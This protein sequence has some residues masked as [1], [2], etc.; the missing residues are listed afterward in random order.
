MIHLPESH[1]ES[2][3]A[4]LEE[5]CRLAPWEAVYDNVAFRFSGA[6]LDGSVAV[7]VG[8][9]GASTGFLVWPSAEDF[10]DFRDAA[11]NATPSVGRLV[12]VDL[13]E[14]RNLKKAELSRVRAAGLALPGDRAPNLH[15]L[16]DGEPASIDA[17]VEALVL[18]AAEA[19]V[20]LVGQH[21]PAL[22]AGEAR[23]EVVRV[24]DGAR[25]EVAAER[26]GFPGEDPPDLFPMDLWVK[27]TTLEDPGGAVPALV[28]R[29][30]KRDADRV[31]AA[32]AGMD[33]IELR[34][35]RSLAIVARAGPRTLG[36]LFRIPAEDADGVAEVL[37]EEAM[38]VIS[39]GGANTRKVERSRFVSARRFPV[40]RA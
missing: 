14:L 15:A 40:V 35:D 18:R 24:R 29:M 33:A 17:D 5:M 20:T 2:W 38:V 26:I 11:A 16:Q 10:E 12:A 27:I 9:M 39:G 21:G 22:A 34:R 6:G 4:V 13:V 7:F 36:L 30:H 37:G 23:S 19:A 3:R 31:A 25:V 28:F 1:L 32:L 8:A